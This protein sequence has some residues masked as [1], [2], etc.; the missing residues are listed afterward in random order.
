MPK[1]PINSKA[2]DMKKTFILYAFLVVV[3]GLATYAV[4]Y[5]VFDPASHAGERGLWGIDNNSITIQAPKESTV[6]Q[7]NSKI[8]VT[9]Q[10]SMLT[11]VK[12]GSTVIMTYLRSGDKTCVTGQ[13]CG[14]AFYQANMPMG[15]KNVTLTQ[16][17]TIPNA[18][19]T[20]VIRVYEVDIT[21]SPL[22]KWSEG[23]VF[24]PS[25]STVYDAKN[26]KILQQEAATISVV[27]GSALSL[28]Y[29]NPYLRTV[30][31]TRFDYTDPKAPPTAGEKA[32]ALSMLSFIRGYAAP[33]TTANPNTVK[34]FA[35]DLEDSK[36]T[37]CA[38][39][40]TA[41]SCGTLLTSFKADGA[42]AVN[43]SDK[44]FTE[45]LF[46]ANRGL[47]LNVYVVDSTGKIIDFATV[48]L[49]SLTDSQ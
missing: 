29:P 2:K 33:G 35:E 16:K 20:Y 43:L 6:T 18:A 41:T 34:V 8:T 46:T 4:Y 28:A 3:L 9:S 31:M 17:L 26:I 39:E 42:F 5:F 47:Y 36:T 1:S 27:N 30:L 37:A 25:K 44:V 21:K 11:K 24:D 23:Q 49:D 19:G 40:S 32:I 7:V 45:N 14:M 13:I 48:Q 15:T 12:T 22:T 38:T 10:I